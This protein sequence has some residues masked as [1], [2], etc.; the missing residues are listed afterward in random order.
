MRLM[1]LGPVGVAL[2]VAGSSL[3][4]PPAIAPPSSTWFTGAF[5]AGAV[6]EA[7]DFN[8]TVRLTQAGKFVTISCNWGVAGVNGGSQNVILEV[9]ADGGAALCSCT[10]AACDATA[11]TSQSC[12][13]GGGSGTA[14]AASTSYVMQ[15]KNTTNCNTNPESIVCNVEIQPP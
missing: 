5:G 9:L 3:F 10:L 2:A 1:M 15:V 8:G 14:Y 11:F 12:V 4:A 7:T 6:A 13:C